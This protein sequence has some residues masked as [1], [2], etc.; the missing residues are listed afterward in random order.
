MLDGERP[1]ARS[2]SVQLVRG[3][4][5]RVYGTWLARVCAHTSVY[6]LL[7]AA[8]DSKKE[9]KGKDPYKGPFKLYIL[10]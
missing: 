1:F 4:T 3:F 2:E 9:R 6:G 8:R 5:W 10:Y 7:R